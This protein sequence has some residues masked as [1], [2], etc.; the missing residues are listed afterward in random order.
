M[1]LM[2]SLALSGGEQNY[3]EDNSLGNDEWGISMSSSFTQT[4][5]LAG[6]AGNLS[7][8]SLW[9]QDP[10]YGTIDGSAEVSVGPGNPVNDGPVLYARTSFGIDGSYHLVWDNHEVAGQ[11]TCVYYPNSTSGSIGGFNN[12]FDGQYETSVI[13]AASGRQ[14]FLSGLKGGEQSWTSS[15]D[16]AEIIPVTSRVYPYVTTWKLRANIPHGN[17]G[18]WPRVDAT[19]I[20][21][22]AGT[23]I[24]TGTIQGPTS[25]DGTQISG[26]ANILQR[27]GCGITSVH[28]ALAT[29]SY[30]AGA[31][32]SSPS[33]TGDGSWRL[34]V[35]AGM[36]VSWA[37]AK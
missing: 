32:M 18:I 28:G 7:H 12:H 33:D 31:V 20:D 27:A 17:N 11:A 22:P 19:C 35:S 8:G 23:T 2:S 13:V 1:Y 24:T 10:N 9:D 15:S 3:Y 37:C 36:T 21:F 4:C 29:D 30:T 16:Y 5:F 26:P 34:A 6:V 25:P 14:C